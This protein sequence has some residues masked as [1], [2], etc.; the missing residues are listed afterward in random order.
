MAI[1]SGLTMAIANPSNQLLMGISFASDLLRN[2][3]GSDIAY[4][5]Q[6]QRMEPLKEAAIAKAAKTAGNGEKQPNE[7]NTA[8]GEADGNIK[9][10]PVFEAVLKGNKDGIVDVVKKSFLKE[11]SQERFL[12]VC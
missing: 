12:M 4:I 3:E 5:E 1:A 7:K 9:K 10:N 11:Q 6:I 2:K 8:V